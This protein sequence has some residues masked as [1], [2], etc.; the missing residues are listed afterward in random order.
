MSFCPSLND[1][2][3]DNPEQVDKYEFLRHMLV[4]AGIVDTGIMDSLHKRFQALD[5]DGSGCL[6]AADLKTEPLGLKSTCDATE[7]SDKV[8]VWP[9][10]VSS[11]P[12][13]A[14][15][16]SSKWGRKSLQ[17]TVRQGSTASSSTNVDALPLA[18]NADDQKMDHQNIPVID[19]SQPTNVDKDLPKRK[20]SGAPAITKRA[21]SPRRPN[22]FV[23]DV[24]VGL[25]SKLEEQR[26]VAGI[27]V[28]RPSGFRSQKE[29][30]AEAAE[31]TTERSSEQNPKTPTVLSVE[32]EK[33]V[34]D[35]DVAAAKELI[36]DETAKASV[37]ESTQTILPVRFEAVPDSSTK[38]SPISRSSSP[39]TPSSRSA[40][41]STRPSRSKSQASPRSGSNS[42]GSTRSSTS[43]LR[44][45]SKNSTNTSYKASVIVSTSRTKP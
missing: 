3:H 33:Q 23:E 19:E 27:H 29:F 13:R 21:V 42:R 10:A 8:L 25:P 2:F 11:V 20:G 43:S 4:Q 30:E 28:K 36:I 16:P 38:L 15:Q 26:G 32:P 7:V 17:R 40:T 31:P 6:T 14:S 37:F 39:G 35:A 34:E 1:F 18:L 24:S 12:S 22:R 44:Q 5:E 9:R 45:D 41:G